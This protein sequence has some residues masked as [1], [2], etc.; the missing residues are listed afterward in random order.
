M[1]VK[2]YIRFKDIPENEVSGVYDGDLGRIRDEAG[3]CCFD[4]IKVDDFY[5]IILPSFSTGGLF[6][7]INFIDKVKYDK[8]PIYLVEGTQ[9][10]LGTYGEPAINNVTILK[11]LS[12]KQF[13][14]PKPE[15]KL[16]PTNKQ[17]VCEER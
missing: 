9:V 3:V 7:L 15:F 11:K 4:F 10:G 16:D 13:A 17:I 1:S 2:Q 8:I 14:D 5:K 12:V 6:D